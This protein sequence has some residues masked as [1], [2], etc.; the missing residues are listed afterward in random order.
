[1]GDKMIYKKFYFENY[2]G[3]KDR[4]EFEIDA[5]SNKPYCI[6][7][8]NESGKTT[9]LK[10]VNI[11]SKL[12]C[13]YKLKDSEISEIKPNIDYFTGEIKM[14][15]ELSFNKNDVNENILNTIN[16][17]NTINIRFFFLFFGYMIYCGISNI[18]SS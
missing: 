4:L 1:M 18:K 6:V 8:N 3:I 13:G 5:N 9:I 16:N 15:A 7:G 11:I 12:C 17:E 2:K 10:G 14:S